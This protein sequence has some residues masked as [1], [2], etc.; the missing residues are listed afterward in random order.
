MQML[1]LCCLQSEL[2]SLAHVHD[3]ADYKLNI[4]VPA[5]KL[6]NHEVSCLKQTVLTGSGADQSHA[7]SQALMIIGC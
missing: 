1:W 2:F 6:L 4:P 5:P 3:I 7:S